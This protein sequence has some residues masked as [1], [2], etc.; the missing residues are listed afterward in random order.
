VEQ[1]EAGVQA[2]KPTHRIVHLRD[3]HFVPKD[4]YESRKEAAL[5]LSRSSDACA[6]RVSRA[7]GAPAS[8]ATGDHSNPH[9]LLYKIGSNFH[10]K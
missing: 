6:S 10:W 4:V 5:G 8:V 1:I 3:W 2:E 9:T 7:A